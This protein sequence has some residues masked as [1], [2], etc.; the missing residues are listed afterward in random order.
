MTKI[1]CEIDDDKIIKLNFEQVISCF[2]N[3]CQYYI[4]EF[5]TL[6]SLI[7]SVEAFF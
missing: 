7:F 4:V 6:N 5:F 3:I 2:L 1:D